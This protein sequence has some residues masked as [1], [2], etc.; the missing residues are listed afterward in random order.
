MR[1]SGDVV[2]ENLEQAKRSDGHVSGRT[3]FIEI[4]DSLSDLLDKMLID[5]ESNSR[6]RSQKAKK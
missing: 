2:V 5:L 4:A 1:K 3:K 6:T